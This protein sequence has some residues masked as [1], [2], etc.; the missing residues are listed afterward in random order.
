MDVSCWE[1]GFASTLSYSTGWE[2]GVPWALTGVASPAQGGEHLGRV[3]AMLV[4]FWREPG[5]SPH[6][7]NGRET[8]RVWIWA[9]WEGDPNSEGEEWAQNG[10]NG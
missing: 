4:T 7:Q 8:C 6:E 9:G 2:A 1:R 3:S 5:S 10:T